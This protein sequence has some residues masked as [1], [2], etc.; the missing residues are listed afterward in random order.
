MPAFRSWILKGQYFQSAVLSLLRGVKI[1]QDQS[2]V[3]LC[4]GN[5]YCFLSWFS[6]LCDSQHFLCILVIILRY[7][8]F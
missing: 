5:L 3:L 6:Q 4:L 1:T 2:R 7:A 8:M